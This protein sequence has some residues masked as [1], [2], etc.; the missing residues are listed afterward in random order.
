MEEYVKVVS[1]NV[2][3]KSFVFLQLLMVLSE[4]RTY[5]LTK[6]VMYHETLKLSIYS[7]KRYTFSVCGDFSFN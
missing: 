7:S 6:T 3:L 2:S 5:E 1:G 4:E